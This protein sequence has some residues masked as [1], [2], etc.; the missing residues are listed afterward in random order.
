MRVPVRRESPKSFLLLQPPKIRMPGLGELPVLKIHFRI[1]AE[2]RVRLR[3]TVRVRVRTRRKW[4]Y[5]SLEL[6]HACLEDFVPLRLPSRWN[7]TID[8]PM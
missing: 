5:T 8:A 7:D 3:V 6:W 4:L 1:Q 2:I